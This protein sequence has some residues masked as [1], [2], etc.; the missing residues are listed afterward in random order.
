MKKRNEMNSDQ[1][2]VIL[3]SGASGV[4]GA[5]L[6]NI[7]LSQF[8]RDFMVETHRYIRN[9]NE[10]TAV[11][12]DAVRKGAAVI[13][14]LVDEKLRCHLLRTA[15][16]AGVMTFDLI[17]PLIEML[18]ELTRAAPEK[19]KSGRCRQMHEDYF[20]RVE[21]MRFT[22]L[23]DDG[24]RADE[25]DEADIVLL[26][27]SRSGKTPLSVYLSVLGWKTANV[28]I[29]TSSSLSDSICRLDRRRVFGLIIDYERLI[30]H[31]KKR[32]FGRGSVIPGY[33]DSASVFNEL[34]W[35]YS[36]YRK[37]QIRTID[38]TDKPIE[39]SAEEILEQVTG[40]R[41]RDLAH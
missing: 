4:G 39:S 12:S 21:A 30:S 29:V 3:V 28:P 5:Q 15:N 31:R 22:T 13:H 38:V 18:T 1:L 24:A 41:R 17:G 11:I 23:H 6:L 2:N 32:R 33:T 36:L 25:I 37:H 16:E 19:E 27:V 20:N 26:G 7:G 10:A 34:E 8:N 14:S 9:E 40:Q 35:A